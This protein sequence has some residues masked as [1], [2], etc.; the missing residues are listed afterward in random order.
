MNIYICE[1]DVLCENDI[2]YAREEIYAVEEGK[3]TIEDAYDIITLLTGIKNINEY[4]VENSQ[5][6]RGYDRRTGRGKSQSDS[7][8]NKFLQDR[9]GSINEIILLCW[10]KPLKR[11]CVKSSSSYSENICGRNS[12]WTIVSLFRPQIIESLNTAA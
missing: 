4:K 7:Y 1:F 3:S 2:D 9:V 12:V 8:Y 5:D 6:A 10:I 11:F